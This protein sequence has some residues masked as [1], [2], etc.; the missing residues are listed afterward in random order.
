MMREPSLPRDKSGELLEPLPKGEKVRFACH[1]GVRCFTDCCRDLHL[2]LTPYDVLRVKRGLAMDSTAF[3]DR[4]TVQETDPTWRIPVVKLQME[5]NVR[6]TCPFVTGEGCRIYPDRPGACRAYPL[7]RAVR[8]SPSRSGPSRVEEEHFLVREP[9]CFGF[10]EGE[11]WTPKAWMENQGL[12]VYNEM[13]DLWMDFLARYKPGSREDLEPPKWKMFF[14]ACYSLDRFRE[15]VFGTRF[16][17]LFSI[18]A[19]RQEELQ[20]SDEALLRFAYT[21]LAYSLFGDPVLEL[22]EAPAPSADVIGDSNRSPKR[23]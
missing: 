10:E 13:N 19:E 14:M 20:Q 17:S 2:V 5:D 8:R 15:F 12:G 1:K 21:W 6:R 18:S 7:G 4:Y 9:H 23:R 3:L 11:L 22:R 16:L